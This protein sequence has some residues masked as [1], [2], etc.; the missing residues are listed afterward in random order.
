MFSQVYLFPIT[1]T[2]ISCFIVTIFSVIIHCLLFTQTK[3]RDT[4]PLLEAAIAY[5]QHTSTLCVKGRSSGGYR[6]LPTAAA[7][8]ETG[9]GHMGFV[10]EKAA[11]G[12]STANTLGFPTKHSIDCSILISMHHQPGLVQ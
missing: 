11:L 4:L 6:W 5:K 10:V 3:K 7:A 9:S 8:L 12:T 2:N 1:A